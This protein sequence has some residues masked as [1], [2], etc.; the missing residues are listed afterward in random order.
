MNIDHGISLPPLPLSHPF[1]LYIYE[2]I[3]KGNSLDQVWVIM[4]SCHANFSLNWQHNI[5]TLCGLPSVVRLAQMGT[6]WWLFQI[7]YQYILTRAKKYW[8]MTWK[9]PL[10]VTFGPIST[11]LGQNLTS[12]LSL[13]PHS[14]RNTSDVNTHIIS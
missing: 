4:N 3:E 1:Y 9:R 13:S 12:V 2:D 5:V 8:N 7:R 11:T 6:N 14:R 10:F